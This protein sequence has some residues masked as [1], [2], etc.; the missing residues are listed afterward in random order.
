MGGGR[1]N[2]GKIETI[3]L[4]GLVVPEESIPSGSIPS[5]PETRNKKW[6]GKKHMRKPTSEVNLTTLEFLLLPE[7]SDIAVG[8][9]VQG[10]SSQS[11][12]LPGALPGTSSVLGSWGCCL[13]CFAGLGK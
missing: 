3:S 8:R 12:P 4:L 6:S 10:V 5:F 13:H 1:G 2:K 7:A 11:Q 9:A